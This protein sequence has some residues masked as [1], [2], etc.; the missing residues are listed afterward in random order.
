MEKLYDAKQYCKKV[1][2]CILSGK[3]VSDQQA[4]DPQNPCVHD[5]AKRMQGPY[6]I[7]I[8]MANLLLHAEPNLENVQT[9]LELIKYLIDNHTNFD[10]HWP[11]LDNN[12]FVEFIDSE[13]KPFRI[14]NAIILDPGHAMEFVGLALKFFDLVLSSRVVLPEQAAYV[15]KMTPYLIMLFQ[16]VFERGFMPAGG[17]CKSFDLLTC[18]PINTDMPWWSLPE[19]MRAGAY[20]VKSSTDKKQQEFAFSVLREC[21]N[22]LLTNYIVSNQYRT[23]IQTRAEDGSISKSIPATADMDPGYHTGLSLIDCVDI[24]LGCAVC[25]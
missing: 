21:Y 4:L 3:F 14:N 18:R 11:E 15:A 16:K 17:F 7:A 1:L 19:T 23:V 9:G 2:D 20:C 8:G 6:M 24:L 22:S 5:P 25:I 12:A 10:G 13:G